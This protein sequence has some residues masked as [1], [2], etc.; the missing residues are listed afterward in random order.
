ME[1][2]DGPKGDVNVEVTMLADST[3]VALAVVFGMVAIITSTRGTRF[4]AR[5]HGL[6]AE[7]APESTSTR[8]SR[9]SSKAK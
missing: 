9:D 5:F 2:K 6:E 4:T 3:I 1:F 8:S 7:S